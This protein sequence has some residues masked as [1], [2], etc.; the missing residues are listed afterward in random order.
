MRSRM[1]S[2]RR[3]REI[4]ES[5]LP[6][7]RRPAVMRARAPLRPPLLRNRVGR[8]ASLLATCLATPR[9]E[10]CGTSSS[11]AATS[12]PSPSRQTRTARRAA[13]GASPLSK[14]P[15]SPPRSA[16]VARGSEAACCASSSQRSDPSSGVSRRLAAA[17]IT[18]GMTPAA[19]ITHGMNAATIAHGMTA[20]TIAHGMTRTLVRRAIA[21][22]RPLGAFVTG[23]LETGPGAATA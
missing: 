21:S 19:T 2:G 18:H 23:T 12:R 4:L 3:G 13:S 14:T 7:V 1:P 5:P 20:A 11:T 10:I 6:A 22:A 17:T 8:A 9:K 16:W 15:P